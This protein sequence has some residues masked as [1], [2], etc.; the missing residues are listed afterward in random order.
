MVPASV[1]G[2]AVEVEVDQELK[3]KEKKKIIFFGKKTI[4]TSQKKKGRKVENL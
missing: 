2:I 4:K 1:E 3:N